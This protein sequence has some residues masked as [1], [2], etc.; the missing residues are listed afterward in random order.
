M[1]EIH[2]TNKDAR[3]L[4]KQVRATN[5]ESLQWIA[6]SIEAQIADQAPT[7]PWRAVE[8]WSRL[9]FNKDRCRL[10]LECGHQKIVR[11]Y[12]AGRKARHAKRVRCDQCG[13]VD[14]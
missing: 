11:G 2:L 10:N 5:V 4:A 8:S 7:A 12:E 9:N 6:D 14:E 1:I 13:Q 3:Q